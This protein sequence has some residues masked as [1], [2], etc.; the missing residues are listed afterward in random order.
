MK[1]INNFVI[2]DA[3]KEE[4]SHTGVKQEKD[5]NLTGPSSAQNADRVAEKHEQNVENKGKASKA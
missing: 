4:I 1:A 3:I 2:I 5:N